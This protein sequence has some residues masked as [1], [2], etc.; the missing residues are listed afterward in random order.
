MDTPQL[1]RYTNTILQKSGLPSDSIIA[2]VRRLSSINIENIFT[3]KPF[4][5]VDEMC[6]R[7]NTLKKKSTDAFRPFISS[8]TNTLCHSMGNPLKV[9]EDIIELEEK[10]HLLNSL[11]RIV[12]F[13]SNKYAMEASN[14]TLIGECH[15]PET[16]FVFDEQSSSSYRKEIAHMARYYRLH[17]GSFLAIE[18]AKELKGFPLSYKDNRFE[19]VIELYEIGCADYIFNFVV[20]TNTNT[21]EEKLVT[22]ILT[23]LDGYRKVLAIHVYGDEKIRLW[24]RWGDD[25]DGLYD[26][27]GN[28]SNT[29]M[30]VSPF[31]NSVAII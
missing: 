8:S 4:S 30:E 24:K 7:L 2:S 10:H 28:R 17:L 18:L 11:L 13:L 23:D 26:I 27:N 22:P 29:H 14:A 6:F 9:A 20:D 12:T 3:Y 19:S 15:Y 1:L 31:F 25:Y 16:S 21:R 5:E